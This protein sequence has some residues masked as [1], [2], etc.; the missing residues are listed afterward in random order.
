M[1][2]IEEIAIGT[3]TVLFSFVVPFVISYGWHMGKWVAPK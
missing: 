3:I 2:T 1:S